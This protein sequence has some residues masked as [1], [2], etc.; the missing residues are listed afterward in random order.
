MKVKSK[1]RGGREAIALPVGGGCRDLAVAVRTIPV[2]GPCRDL[3]AAARVL[4]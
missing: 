3:T 2:G 4:A 1:V